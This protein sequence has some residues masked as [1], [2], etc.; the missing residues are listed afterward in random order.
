[1]PAK[2]GMAAAL[3]KKRERELAASRGQEIAANDFATLEEQLEEFRDKLGA[4]STQ[5]Q[6]KIRKDP[7]FRKQFTEMCA[8]LGVDPL[9]SSKNMW[10]SMSGVGDFYYELAV[11]AIEI[12]IATRKRNGGLL[13]INELFRLLVKSRGK[14]K[15]KISLDD[16]KQSLKNLKVLGSGFQMVT[17]GRRTFVQSVPSEMGPDPERVLDLAEQQGGVITAETLCATE[18]WSV[19]RAEGVLKKLLHSSQAWL[20]K[21][22]NGEEAYWFPAL[23]NKPVN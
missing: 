6:E 5:Y 13:E 11:Q 16:L 10:S 15:D 3:A 18:R 1:M 8:S 14:H 7:V 17:A 20:D 22:S 23:L 21:G 2:R 4:F 12:C 9:S 19:D